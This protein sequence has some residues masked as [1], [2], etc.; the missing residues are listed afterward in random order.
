MKMKRLGKKLQE[1]EG[2]IGPG[3]TRLQFSNINP[4]VMKLMS[5]K[6]VNDTL[7]RKK[8]YVKRW[9]SCRNCQPK[10]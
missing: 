3:Q 10:A 8:F 5:L 6:C 1:S 7:S 9:K 4:S 2:K